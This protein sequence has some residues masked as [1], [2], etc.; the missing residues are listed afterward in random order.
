MGL[1]IKNPEVEKLATE[2]APLAR[3]SKTEATR[4]ALILRKRALKDRSPQERAAKLIDH[5]EKNVWPRLP[6][7]IR[8][9]RT[10]KAEREQILGIGEHGYCE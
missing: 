10:T 5:L 2:V 6:A 1:N 3:E 8:G 4:Q 9:K 7:E